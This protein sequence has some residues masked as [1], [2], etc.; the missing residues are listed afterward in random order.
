MELIVINEK[1]FKLMLDRNDME[2]YRKKGSGK[3]VLREIINDVRVKCGYAGIDGRIFVQ[4]YSSSDGSC[5]LFVTRL[6]NRE[7]NAS[8]TEIRSSKR[9]KLE[10]INF[11]DRTGN[12]HMHSGEEK[13]LTEYRKNIYGNRKSHVVYSFENMEYLLMTCRRLKEAGY[14]ASSTSYA[15]KEKGG[16]YL[17]LENETPIPGENFGTLCQSSSYYYIN[18]HCNLICPKSVEKLWDLAR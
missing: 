4:M 10:N 16:Y 3:E 2:A 7:T 14:T 15:D 5:E 12:I 6:N 8:D 17:I 9:E 11:N 18:E 1:K 13:I